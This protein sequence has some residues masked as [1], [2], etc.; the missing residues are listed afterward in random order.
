MVGQFGLPK[1]LSAMGAGAAIISMVIW[2]LG[3]LR[4]GTTAEVARHFSPETSASSSRIAAQALCF[5]I[6]LGLI[7]AAAT[8]FSANLLCTMIN[9]G[10]A[11]SELTTRYIEIR[12]WGFPAALANMVITG[13]LIGRQNPT[14]CLLLVSSCNVLNLLL[15][16]TAVAVFNLG[17]EGVAAA[18]VAAEYLTTA[19]GLCWLFKEHPAKFQLKA[20]LLKRFMQ[21]NTVLFVR[22]AFL[23]A[24][25]TFF[26]A[27]SARLGDDILALNTVLLN[28]LLLV[29]YCMDGVANGMEA[30]CGQALG[31]KNLQRYKALFKTGV[32]WTL[33]F[34]LLFSG[35][36]AIGNHVL[37]ELFS[38]DTVLLELFDK[39]KLWLFVF[40]LISA[41]AYFL[42][43]VFIAA[44]NL[45]AMRN[46]VLIASISYMG[47]WLLLPDW[48]T[49]HGL[50]ALFLAFHGFRVIGLLAYK[51]TWWPPANTS[52]DT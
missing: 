44:D 11:S 31:Q 36:F 32:L 16:I 22:S 29:S 51:H 1:D 15:S 21:Q 41:W 50:W 4:M 12:S 19:I 8:Y 30:L 23:V 39:Y 48:H 6:T 2:L 9:P 43:G 37:F 34:S 24:G 20:E 13:W 42:D 40:P 27:Q 38:R 33:G 49:N 45:K 52:A 47:F 46:T 17:A 35:V 3:F 18:T 26:T 25:M 7:T 5:A 14:R 28:L 10:N